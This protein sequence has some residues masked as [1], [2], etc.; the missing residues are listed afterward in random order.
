MYT[1]DHDLFLALNFDGGELLDQAMLT[2]SG[3]AMWIPLY[4]LIFYLVARDYG[5]RQL[6]IFILLLAAAMG[7]ADIVAGIF[8]QSGL[9]EGALP[10]LTPR[11]RPMFEPTLEGLEITPDS[12]RVL[13]KGAL[14]ADPAVHAPI[15]AVSGR[16]GTVSAHAS[17]V[18]ALCY[19]AS[20][21]LR[22]RWF[23][24][25]MVACTLLICYSRIY[26]A[27]HYPMD[28]LWGALLGIALGWIAYR[29]FNYTATLWGGSA[30]HSR[31]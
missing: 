30:K 29:L 28:L 31:R 15:E 27:K 3:T 2:I 4:L 5:W 1:F 9:L 20:R 24:P 25:L 8:K 11:W 21:V 13:R 22:R 10:N 6:V 17:T 16:Y 7:L 18:C 26:L 12:L 19:L 14:L 23:T